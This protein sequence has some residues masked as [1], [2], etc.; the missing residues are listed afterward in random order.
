ME[1]GNRFYMH[2]YSMQYIPE[3]MELHNVGCVIKFQLYLISVS[4]GKGLKKGN[5]HFLR[6]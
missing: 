2:I 3:D 5:L 6:F 4:T 1:M